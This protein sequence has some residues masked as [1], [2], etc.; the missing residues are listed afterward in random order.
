MLRASFYSVSSLALGFFMLT[1]SNCALCTIYGPNL[2]LRGPDGSMDRPA[3]R[4][5]CTPR[6]QLSGVGVGARAR[7]A[8]GSLG[9]QSSPAPHARD[10]SH[11]CAT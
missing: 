3:R 1:V 9:G 5:C 8:A 4:P 11:T 6:W 2:A 7:G 10:T